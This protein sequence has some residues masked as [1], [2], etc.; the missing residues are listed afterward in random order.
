MNILDAASSA[1]VS[2]KKA[3]STKGGEYAGPCPGCGGK[4][5]F[6]CWP[7]EKGGE[8]SYWC[9][10][11]NSGGDLVQFLKDYLGYSYPDAF[12]AAGRSR[13]DDYRTT[14]YRPAGM[15]GKNQSGVA[16]YKA[17]PD[18]FTPRTHESPVETWQVKAEGFV[19][20]SHNALLKHEKAMKYL[21]SRGLDKKAVKG[22]RLGW[23]AG[24]NGK[25][26]A[27]R[28]RT[29]WGLSKIK[30]EKTGRDK[31]LWLPRGIVIPCFKDNKV[32]RVRI[33]RP[34]ADIKTD[35]DVKYYVMP[36]SGMEVMDINTDKK[37]IVIVEAELDAMLIARH[38]GSLTGVVSLGSAMNKPGSTVFYNLKK[39]LRILVAL[40]YDAAGQKAWQWWSQNFKN[41]KLWPVPDGKDPGE[42]FEKGVDIKSWIRYGLPPAVT[43]ESTTLPGYKIPE[44]VYPMQELQQLLQKYPVTI[45]AEKQKAKIMFDPGFKN[46][47][48]K[49]RINDIFFGDDEV[50]WYLRMYHPDSIINGD[51]C[52]VKKS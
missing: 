5:R 48:I 12:A 25:N 26:C 51:N 20:K 40:D 8:G 6:R 42:A 15:S 30:N 4:D 36:G 43:M 45:Q 28:P 31:M 7:A 17:I 23:F 50:H 22:F 29:S 46:R 2:L 34:K 52:H 1:G 41:A 38:A 13:P 35:R 44:G 10:G 47:A 33:R 49:Q 14:R 9:R 19:N 32:Y 39:T 24:E 21:E 27:F 18:K 37:S 16:D 11:C 3:A